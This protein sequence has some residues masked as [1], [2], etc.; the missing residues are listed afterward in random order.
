MAKITI[1][2]EMNPEM[3]L[4]LAMLINT[5]AQGNMDVYKMMTEDGC[6][7]CMDVAQEITDQVS[8][9]VPE[10]YAGINKQFNSTN[11]KR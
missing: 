2:L 8:A 4:L 11:K 9:T 10:K 7:F 5:T 1:T 6:K 3:A